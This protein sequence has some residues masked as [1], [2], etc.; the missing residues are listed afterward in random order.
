MRK[1]SA[2]LIALVLIVSGAIAEARAETPEERVKL[3]TRV[4]GA[5]GS[6]IRW[7]FGLDSMR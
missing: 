5:F 1:T 3:G 4:H 2:R 6:F 7:G